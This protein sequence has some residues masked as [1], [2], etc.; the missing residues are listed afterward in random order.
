MVPFPT[1]RDLSALSLRDRNNESQPTLLPQMGSFSGHTRPVDSLALDLHDDG[2]SSSSPLLYSADS[3]GVIKA[4]RLDVNTRPD[5]T[6][7][8]RGVVEADYGG[9]RTGVGEL[10]ISQQHIW[11]GTLSIPL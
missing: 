8:V 10:W 7:S 5:G 2:S 9:H 1:N 11:S 3:M 6:R 4:W